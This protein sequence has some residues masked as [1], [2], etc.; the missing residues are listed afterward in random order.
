[1]KSFYCSILI[2]LFI[3][4]SESC[5][6][7]AKD[8]QS[9]VM[10]VYRL[11]ILLPGF[12]YEKRV[13]KL[14]TLYLDASLNIITSSGRFLSDIHLGPSAMAGV[15]NYYNIKKRENKGLRT[16][17][18]SANYISP[19]LFASTAKVRSSGPDFF[20]VIGAVWGL[21]R[22]YQS[23]FSLDLNAGLGYGFSSYPSI[24]ELQIINQLKLGIWLN[25]VK[26]T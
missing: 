8:T 15:R 13:S 23:K 17:L 9:D 3:A 16:T 2:I 12:S 14:T 11:N 7:Q 18:N 26:R 22:N 21:Q 24:K 5:Y 19:I 4:Y 25:K 1:M 20:G 6:S 10:T